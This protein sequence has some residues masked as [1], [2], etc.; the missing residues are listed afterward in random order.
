[1]H[2][3]YIW[4]WRVL[5]SLNL[6]ISIFSLFWAANNYYAENFL[7]FNEKKGFIK[8][9]TLSDDKLIFSF[10]D[11]NCQLEFD[12][13][14]DKPINT[15]KLLKLIKSMDA[16]VMFVEQDCSDTAEA[17]FLNFNEFQFGSYDSFIE[18][19]KN[20]GVVYFFFSALCIGISLLSCIMLRVTKWLFKRQSVTRQGHPF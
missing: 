15:E 10:R 13:Y 1:M 14:T 20:T 7:K 19:K 4:F 18:K 12:F 2:R 11:S 6:A 9:F 5:T 8:E 16:D 17:V 3:N